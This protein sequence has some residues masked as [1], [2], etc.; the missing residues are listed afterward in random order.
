MSNATSTSNLDAATNALIV[1]HTF[2]AL[3]S[4]VIFGASIL[5]KKLAQQARSGERKCCR[6]CP[7]FVTN[8]GLGLLPIYEVLSLLRACAMTTGQIMWMVDGVLVDGW[9]QFH[10]PIPIWQSLVFTVYY[11]SGHAE[12]HFISGPSGGWQ[13]MRKSVA[14]A[15]TVV[16]IGTVWVALIKTF[17]LDP[18]SKALTAQL[19]ETLPWYSD[20]QLGQLAICSYIMWTKSLTYLYYLVTNQIRISRGPAIGACILSAVWGV[21]ISR[22]VIKFDNKSDEA[23]ALTPT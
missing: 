1:I 23:L 16:V 14:I 7:A 4:W 10:H 17:G 3:K 22:F 5:S 19:H 13:H 8:G 18:L 9:G 15:A 2:D 11:S 21:V 20:S 6:M 12:A